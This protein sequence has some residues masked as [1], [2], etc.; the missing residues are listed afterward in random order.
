MATIRELL[1]K[2]KFNFKDCKIIYQET[3]DAD[4]PGWSN[5]IAAR[6]IDISDS[7]LDR[8]FDTGY[9]GPQMPRFIA[10]DDT[11]IYFPVQYDGSTWIAQVYKDINK[12]LDYENNITPYPGG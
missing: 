12:Y 1:T 8:E 2:Q 11:A 5:P 4:T 10:E 3:E 9:G 6:V 7:V